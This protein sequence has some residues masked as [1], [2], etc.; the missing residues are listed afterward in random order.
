[1]TTLLYRGQAYEQRSAADSLPNQLRY[2]REVYSQRQQD[3]GR[4]HQLTYRGCPYVS[5]QASIVIRQGN[6]SY[7]GVAYSL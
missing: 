4:S 3:A 2:D 7:R 6:Y 1:M 5:G